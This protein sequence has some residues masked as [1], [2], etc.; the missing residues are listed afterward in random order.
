MT[1]LA[2]RV[3]Q[4]SGNAWLRSLQDFHDV[5]DAE[6]PT[7]QDMENP[8][9]RSVGK[10]PEH[11]VDAA[12]HFGL[13]GLGHVRSRGL[14][15]AHHTAQGRCPRVLSHNIHYQEGAVKYRLPRN[16]QLLGQ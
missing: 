5:S 12:E 16:R 4:V 11:Q 13:C 8:Q 1:R 14:V 3:G 15:L 6:F 7:Q 9:S 2:L 10:R